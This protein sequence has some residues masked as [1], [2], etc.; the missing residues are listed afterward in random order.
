[1]PPPG[2]LGTRLASLLLFSFP[3]LL[4]AVPRGSGVFLIGIFA[5]VL[6]NLPQMGTLHRQY[7]AVLLPVWMSVLAVLGVHLASKY[8]FGLPWD[9]LD[10]PSRVLAIPL[11]CLVVLRYRPD[12]MLLW[13]GIPPGLLL[14]LL[15]V[16]WQFFVDKEVRPG[17]WTFIIAFANM[18]ATLGVIGFFRPGQTHRDHVMAWLCPALAMVVLIMNGSR[19]A[20]LAL[21]L[22]VVVSIY[23]RYQRFSPKVALVSLCSL[24]FIGFVAWSVPDSPVK[25]RIEQARHDVAQFQQGNVDT[26]LGERLRIFQLAVNE[27]RQHPLTGVGSGEFGRL[28]DALPG[29]PGDQKEICTL[30][31]AHNDLLDAAATTGLPGLAA[32]LSLL[33]VPGF[34]F[35][36]VLR[37]TCGRDAMAPY[38]GK[39]GMGAV[40]ATLICGFS[41]VT[42]AHQANIAF[43]ASL[44]GLLLGLAAVRM[45][46]LAQGTPEQ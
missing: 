21:V 3:L 43:Y 11:V 13:K 9:V 5:L 7:R 31:H 23:F 32:F 38:L 30:K 33:L 4:L 12:P 29:C 46:T 44:M 24:A 36:G 40:V 17:A 10:N 34:I 42:M 27:V 15:I 18:V 6:A 8:M 39:A 1:M 2:T 16:A 37:T 26:S 20:W 41:Q 35:F 25:Q 28:T 22:T 14:A 45:H 19:G